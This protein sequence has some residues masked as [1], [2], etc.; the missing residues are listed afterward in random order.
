MS[1]ISLSTSN[2]DELNLQVSG[3]IVMGPVDLAGDVSKKFTPAKPYEF[4]AP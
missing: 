3:T 4:L 2:A 1:T